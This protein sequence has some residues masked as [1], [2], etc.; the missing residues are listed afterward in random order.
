M[1]HLADATDI[2]ALRHDAREA[3]RPLQPIKITYVT[4]LPTLHSWLLREVTLLR[5]RELV[6]RAQATPINVSR[7]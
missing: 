6:I 4:T 7:T 3:T 2:A 1:H 5:G